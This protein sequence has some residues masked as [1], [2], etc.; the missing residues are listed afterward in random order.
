MEPHEHAR[1]TAPGAVG[2]PRDPLV[3][4]LLDRR[5][6]IGARVARGGMASVYEATD[7][8]LD[9]LVAVKVMHPGLGDDQEFAQRF[10]DSGHPDGYW[11]EH[12]NA[13]REGGPSL[14]YTRVTA[15]CLF[16]VLGGRDGS[17]EKFARAG[18][19]YRSFINHDQ[20]MIPLADERTNG[21]AE[22]ADA[23]PDSPNR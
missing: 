3:G 7:T 13:E 6:R 20:A 9:R 16:D 23:V 1:A 14:L 10:Y 17:L 15:S 22:G 21:S 5:Y 4:R 12:T 18:D 8:R 2:D 11:E 19:F